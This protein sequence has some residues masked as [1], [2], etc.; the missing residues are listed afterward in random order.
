MRDFQLPG[1]SAVIAANAMAASSH[2]LGTQTAIKILQDGGNA[3]DAAIA[4][5]LVLGLTEP[6]STGIGGD[7]FVLFTPPG[8]NDIKAM[9]SSGR[10]PARFDAAA[11]RAGGA[12]D[13]GLT[14]PHAVTIPG[15]IDGFCRLAQDWGKLDLAQV[16]APAIDLAENGIPVSARVAYDWRA[17]SQVLSGAAR[18]WYLQGDAPFQVGQTWRHSGQAEILR[19]V[20]RL[21]R[22]GFYGGEVAEDMVNSLRALGGTHDLS[23]FAQNHCDYTDPISD[24]YRGYEMLQHRPNGQGA[25]AVLLA[26]ILE[27]FDLSTLDP[28]GVKRAHIEAE[29]AKL[30]HDAR[31]RFLADAAHV[32]RLDHMLSRETAAKLADLID[33]NRALE[34]PRTATGNVHKDT[35]YLSVV[36]RDRMAVSLIY[37]IFHNFGS[38][39]AS[40]RFGV[41]FHNRGSGFSLQPGHPNEAAPSKRPLHTIIPG[42]L[43]HQGRVTMPFGVMGGQYQPTGQVRVMSNMLDFG[44]DVQEAIDGPRSFAEDGILLMER[45]YDPDVLQALSDMGHHVQT[46][47]NPIGGG[48]AIW[49]DHAN[50]TLHAGSDPRKDGLALGY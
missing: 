24:S 31:D 1:R 33:P 10:A 26:N 50:G 15:A 41:L 20:A 17:N 45:G 2:P 46:P 40:D 47:P 11:L 42:M 36:D 3:M 28:W 49:I 5:A 38:G 44:M 35:V 32:T 14:S 22:D 27:N 39:L 29:A 9:N 43:R 16:L 30:A 23:D 13:I 7:M 12:T 25:T 48:Q 6:A 34:T 19:R 8:S 18:K 21:G 37:S 4:C